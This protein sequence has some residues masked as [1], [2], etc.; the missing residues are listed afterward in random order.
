V[1]GGLGDEHVTIGLDGFS[2]RCADVLPDNEYT[3]CKV[4][5]GMEGRPEGLVSTIGCWVVNAFDSIPDT[6]IGVA[7]TSIMCRMD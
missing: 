7:V 2:G 5:V 1:R 3:L 4:H 6:Q